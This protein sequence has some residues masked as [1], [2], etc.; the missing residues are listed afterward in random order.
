MGIIKDAYG[1][2]LM[3]PASQQNKRM[4]SESRQD[5]CNALRSP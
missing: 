3:M 2:S 4:S 1:E 5:I